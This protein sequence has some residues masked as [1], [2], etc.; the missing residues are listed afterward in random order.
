M[1][2]DRSPAGRPVSEFHSQS[3]PTAV[4]VSFRIT[5]GTPSSFAG[6]TRQPKSEFWSRRPANAPSRPIRPKLSVPLSFLFPA[7]KGNRGTPGLGPATTPHPVRNPIGL[8]NGACVPLQ[9]Q[10]CPH[11]LLSTTGR[12]LRGSTMRTWRSPQTLTHEPFDLGPTLPPSEQRTHWPASLA[13]TKA[14]LH[15]TLDTESPIPQPHDHA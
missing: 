4:T 13:T 9:L 12:R 11:R 1:H 6:S 2:L 5:S 10:V 3:P 8:P 7:P 14:R 15:A